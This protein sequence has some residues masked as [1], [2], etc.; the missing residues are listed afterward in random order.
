MQIAG[1][2]TDEAIRNGSIKN[3]PDKRRNGR[4]PSK[5]RNGRDDNK[6][7][8]T[9]NDFA[10]TTNPVRR[11]NIRAEE[12]RQ[13]P[14]I[15]TSMFTL[16][17]HYAATLFD[18]GAD[19]SFVSTTFIHLLGIEPSDLAMKLRLLAGLTP[20]RE[21]KFQIELVPG[22]IPVMK[23]PYQ[24]APSK[25]KEFRV[26]SKNSRTRVLF[27]QARCLGEHRSRY[28]Q[29][30]VHEDD[31]SK[32]MFRTHYGHFKFTEMPFGL[33]NAP[34]LREVQFLGNVVNGDGIHVDPSKIE[35]V[36]NW[37]APRTPSKFRLFL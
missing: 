19:Y 28:H 29:L 30:R 15:V 1:T 14:D 26:N 27:D 17:N 16:N 24:L 32:T 11:E 34:A 9:G 20:I 6:R 13:D 37:E 4:E 5:D 33:T 7:T 22:A 18:S 35:A 23:S 3:N 10:T 36:K 25:M 31:I 21:I 2:L 8:R 12:A